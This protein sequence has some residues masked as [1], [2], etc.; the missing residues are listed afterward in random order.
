[1]SVVAAIVGLALV[2]VDGGIVSVHV[3]TRTCRLAEEV[4]FGIGLLSGHSSS[5]LDVPLA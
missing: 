4:H 3:A 2:D 5:R 1:L